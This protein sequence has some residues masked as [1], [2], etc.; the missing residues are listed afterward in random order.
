MIT[1][2]KNE[3]ISCGCP[4]LGSSSGGLVFSI[5]GNVPTLPRRREGEVQAASSGSLWRLERSYCFTCSKQ[6]KDRAR[7][8]V[9]G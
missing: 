5:C 8:K 6:V 1:F 9:S 3:D 7:V 4:P 2:E